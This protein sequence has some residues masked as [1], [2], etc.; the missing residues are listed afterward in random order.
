MHN[1]QQEA[2]G[3]LRGCSSI[4]VDFMFN[5][6]MRWEELIELRGRFQIVMQYLLDL[7]YFL[8]ISFKLQFFFRFSLNAAITVIMTTRGVMPPVDSFN[9]G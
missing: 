9:W 3:H 1:I 4:T 2:S 7:L 6:N 5:P 8:Y